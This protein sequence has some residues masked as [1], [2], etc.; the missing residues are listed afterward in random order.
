M[1]SQRVAAVVLGLT[2]CAGPAALARAEA[3]DTEL[4]SVTA[5]GTRAAGDSNLRPGGGALSADGRF[6]VF[7]SYR[8]NL[9]HNDHNGLADVFLRDLER[10][11]TRLL[12]A[13]QG[14]DA[15]NGY[16]A[17]ASL[18][19]DGQWASFVST[20]SDLVPGDT[21]DAE[22]AFVWSR[23]G[24]R[25]ERAS[26]RSDG[27]QANDASL[28]AALSRDG[29]YVAFSS[30]ATNLAA[31]DTNGMSDVFLRDRQAG[32]TERISVGRDGRP[33][34]GYSWQPSVSDDGRSVAFY[35]TA[36]NL[37]A[38]DRGDSE[39]VFVHDRQ[40]RQT[41]RASEAAD[42]TPANGYSV[43]PAMSGDGR[44]V[45]FVSAATNLVPGDTNRRIDVFVKE[46]ATGRVERVSVGADG[47]QANGGSYNPALSR[48]GR[49][50][51]F[52]SFASNLVRGDT[53]R[54]FD[55][56]VHDR[57]TRR[58]RRV[59]LSS[60][61]VQ[62][63]GPNW[64]PSLSADGRFVAFR[65]DATNLAAV[66]DNDASDVYEREPGGASFT[67]KPTALDFGSRPVGAVTTLQ[68]WLHNR[69]A[70]PLSIEWMALRGPDEAQFSLE[71]HC[72]TQVAPGLWCRID[73]VF[74]PTW[75]GARSA[76]LKVHAAGDAV[77]TRAIE[78][79]GT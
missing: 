13:G 21:N 23:A 36:S 25:L 11:D 30:F 42:G 58:T 5:S 57:R 44:Y 1:Q 29:R 69:S 32:Y 19:A 72:G 33:A 78:G 68:F 62:A 53:N 51:I 56:F 59:S 2:C 10:G 39:D 40:T 55:V 34:N 46:L 22:D 6:V 47:A 18:S 17:D 20:S 67:I 60:D 37:V 49:Y 7:H 15:G 70:R 64:T 73:V 35:S 8:G 27:A 66:D 41:V 54:S 24:G 65:S 74:Q 79:T 77:R 31:G 75:A 63:N 9:V 76:E 12:S 28:E 71:Q 43:Q 16:S 26:V 4:V 14:G 52:E 61:G 45:A 48:D 50:V 38:G 3:G